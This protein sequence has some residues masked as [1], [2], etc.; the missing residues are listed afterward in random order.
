[1]ASTARSG[2]RPTCDRMLPA[3][4]LG[5]AGGVWL[6]GTAA[7]QTPEGVAK[8]ILE[9]TGVKGGLIVHLGCG[10]GKVTAALH[11][12]NAYLVHGIDTD[13]DDVAQ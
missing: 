7:G 12:S 6:C 8:G 1:M 9:A 5:L 13:A 4:L 10:D 2:M 11:A 3:V